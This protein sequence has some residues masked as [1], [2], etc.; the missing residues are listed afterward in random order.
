MKRKPGAIDYINNGARY[1]LLF[2]VLYL[3]VSVFE[4]SCARPVLNSAFLFLTAPFNPLENCILA[5]SSAGFFVAVASN[6]VFV[7]ILIFGAGAYFEYLSGITKRGVRM[8]YVFASAVI[9]TY[10]ASAMSFLYF[11]RFPELRLKVATGTSIIG[12]DMCM[13]MAL[14]MGIEVFYYLKARSGKRSLRRSRKLGF[15]PIYVNTRV[16]FI[17]I[18]LILIYSYLDVSLVHLAGLIAI[19]ILAVLVLSFSH[20]S[21][22]KAMR[23]IGRSSLNGFGKAYK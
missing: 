12:F 4:G 23:A 19:P 16:G 10:I 5:S 11:S 3:F 1:T 7:A 2:M 6:F 18:F 8:S 9:S 15:D 13:F 22:G 21:L 20:M 17:L 14:F